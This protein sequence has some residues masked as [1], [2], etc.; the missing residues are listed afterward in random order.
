MLETTIGGGN[1]QRTKNGTEF[2][3]DIIPSG[4]GVLTVHLGSSYHLSLPHDPELQDL[5]RPAQDNTFSTGDTKTSYRWRLYVI[6]E[7]EGFQISSEATYVKIPGSV[8]WAL[9]WNIGMADISFSP[10]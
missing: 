7:Y 2:V 9:F 3:S 1:H 5:E 6:I 8:S 10:L 4:P